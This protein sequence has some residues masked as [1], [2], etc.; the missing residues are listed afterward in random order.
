MTEKT[1]LK[2]D[3]IRDI[4]EVASDVLSTMAS[5]EVKA[6]GCEQSNGTP[7]VWTLLPAWTLPG[8]WDFRG[9]EKAR[10]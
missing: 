1:V 5:Y 9:V 7:N 2:E 10:S 3:L 4:V 8:Y 6:K